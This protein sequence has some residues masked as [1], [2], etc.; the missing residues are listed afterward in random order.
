MGVGSSLAQSM[1]AQRGKGAK[2]G[3]GL[4]SRSE[5]RRMRGG[6]G[7]SGSGLVMGNWDKSRTKRVPRAGNWSLHGRRRV[8]T[9]SGGAQCGLCD[10]KGDEEDSWVWAEAAAPRDGYVQGTLI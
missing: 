7:S 5:M 1:R 10:P 3:G 4:W 2:T 6:G 8:T 9:R